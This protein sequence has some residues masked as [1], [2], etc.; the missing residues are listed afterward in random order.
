MELKEAI[1]LAGIIANGVTERSNIMGKKRTVEVYEGYAAGTYP[2]ML[3][4]NYDDILENSDYDPNVI[5]WIW[6]F[7]GEDN[8]VY[9]LS[10]ITSQAFTPKSNAAKIFAGITGQQMVGGVEVEDKELWGVPVLLTI[11]LNK[12]ADGSSDN[13]ITAVA[14]MTKKQRDQF[15]QDINKLNKYREELQRDKPPGEDAEALKRA[16]TEGRLQEDAEFQDIPF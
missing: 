9:K 1:I 14:A 13:K 5:R 3:D 10:T 4:E 11:S 15:K 8:Q 16:R 12:K 6:F 7:V 2:A